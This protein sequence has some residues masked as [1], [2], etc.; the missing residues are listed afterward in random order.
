MDDTEDSI[1][2]LKIAE[3]VAEANNAAIPGLLL[4]LKPLLDKASVTSQEVR[5]IRR[6]IWKYDLL[7]WCAIALQYEYTRVKGGL[8]SAVRIS[9]IL[10]DCCC[11]ID[12]NES[13]EFSQ[14]TLPSAVHSF[15]KIIRQFQQRI[16]EKLKPPILQTVTDAE[17]CDEMLTLL[18]SLIT[19]H[20][21]LC[22][23]LLSCGDLLRII[24]EDNHGHLISL[25]AI[26]IIDRA[27]RVN[28]HCVSQV[29]RPTIQSLLDELV[30]KLTS[31]SDE[32]LAKSSSRL[33]VSLSDAHPPLVPLMV[34][35][36]KGLKVILRRWDGQ[37]FDRELSK[38]VAVLEAGTVE[39]A[40]LY[41]KRNA[42]A[43]IWAYY[44]GW[45]ARTRVAKLKQAIPKLQGS[46]RRR[47]EERV[48]EEEMERTGRLQ[49]SQQKL[50]NRRSFRKMREK[51]LVA[52]EIVPAGR[53]SDHIQ[54]E[55]SS[56]AVRIQAHWRAHK[57]RKVFSAKRKVH[58]ENSAAVVIQKQVKKFLRKK[59]NPEVLV[60]GSLNQYMVDNDQREKIMGKIKNWQTVNKRSGVPIDEA[61]KIHERAQQMLLLHHRR[62]LATK[63]EEEQLR[64]MM[65]RIKMDEDVLSDLP[66]LNEATE[67]SVDLLA[68]KSSIVQAAAEIEHHKQLRV[69]REPW[70]KRLNDDNTD[71]VDCWAK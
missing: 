14:S 12:V 43:V 31:L 52:M 47:R 56:A 45:K 40:K 30:Y 41:R 29:D 38:L 53:I 27:I 68:C 22:K 10:C 15:L 26:S 11:H 4:Q 37:G 57:Q 28:R 33:I 54:D 55:E 60:A 3:L 58:R 42:V 18:T 50:E 13:Q 59:T 19:S 9:H 61:T 64:M 51:Q 21:H 62:K 1:E 65:I 49:V 46:F 2:V 8:E 67:E 20:P 25:R 24:M 71:D 5:V 48:G 34:T 69:N 39:N 66:P 7:S 44:Q 17:L 23:P 6:S 70:W 35:R 32:D 63:N 36:F 16:E